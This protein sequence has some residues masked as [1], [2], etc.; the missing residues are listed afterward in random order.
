MKA[1]IRKRADNSLEI[2]IPK[3]DL[4]AV[5]IRT[6]EVDGKWG[7][8]F[9]LANG[10]KIQVPYFDNEPKLPITLEVRKVE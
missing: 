10:W 8:I 6:E 2:Y 3:K 5:V 7:G 9:E 4:E 1:T